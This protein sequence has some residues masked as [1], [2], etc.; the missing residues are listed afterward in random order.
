[1]E[2]L[3]KI[4]ALMPFDLKRRIKNAVLDAEAKKITHLIKRRRIKKN[5]VK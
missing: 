1:M 4:G 3:V 2:V 5:E